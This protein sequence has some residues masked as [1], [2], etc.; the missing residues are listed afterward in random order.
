M[1]LWQG[2]KI[3]TLEKALREEVEACMDCFDMPIDKKKAK[4]I[5]KHL[6]NNKKNNDLWDRLNER[7]AEYLNDIGIL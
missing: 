5:T 1:R 3:S 6:M 4:E 7:I 2:K